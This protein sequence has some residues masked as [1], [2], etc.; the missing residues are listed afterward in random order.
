MATPFKITTLAITG[1]GTSTIGDVD[2]VVVG[3][4]AVNTYASL[5]VGGSIVV[6][7]LDRSAISVG[8]IVIEVGT[9]GITL[10]GND[11]T[12]CFIE[13]IGKTNSIALLYILGSID[14]V[15]THASLFV[16]VDNVAYNDGMTLY[17]PNTET[18]IVVSN[19]ATLWIKG[20]TLPSTASITL[21]VVMEEATSSSF[22]L[23]IRTP[24]GFTGAVPYEDTIT[25]FINRPN[26]SVA[27]TLFLKAFD[28]G[29]NSYVPLYI[30][31]F[32]DTV[33]FTTLALPY[34]TSIR[35]N[36]Y[37]SLATFGVGIIT[38]GEAAITV[39]SVGVDL[40]GIGVTIDDP[41]GSPPLFTHGHGSLN[42]VAP[43]FIKT[44]QATNVYTTLFIDGIGGRLSS[45]ITLVMPDVLDVTPASIPLF[46]FGW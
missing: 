7:T 25:L 5:Y 6:E 27:T 15:N 23:Y 35:I 24:V 29:S 9:F 19:T 11:D 12:P 28:T 41:G 13:G 40:S 46:V 16:Q 18:E 45:E 42:S 2:L 26:E 34:V 44:A 17:L 31:S 1:S 3:H 39:G 33:G 37:V 22:P 8:T 14:T 21:V 30:A 38:S 20:G 43:L 36:S 32:I 4:I 10:F